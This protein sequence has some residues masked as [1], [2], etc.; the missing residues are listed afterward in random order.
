MASPKKKDYLD[1]LDSS[2]VNQ[3]RFRALSGV[4]PERAEF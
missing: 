2:I 3:S 1:S 4:V